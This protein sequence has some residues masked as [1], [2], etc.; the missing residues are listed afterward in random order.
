MSRT[1]SAVVTE[2]DGVFIALNPETSVASQGPTIN[3]ALTNL[4]EALELYLEETATN[5]PTITSGTTF[6]TTLTI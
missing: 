5:G 6:L 4:K 1:F 3:D 2:E